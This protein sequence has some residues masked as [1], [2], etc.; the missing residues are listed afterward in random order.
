MLLFLNSVAK[1]LLLD[2]SCRKTEKSWI[3]NLRYPLTDRPLLAILF[4]TGSDRVK[5]IL[6]AVGVFFKAFFSCCFLLTLKKRIL[7]T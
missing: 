4:I 1:M 7:I 6:M 2:L 5:Q 3:K